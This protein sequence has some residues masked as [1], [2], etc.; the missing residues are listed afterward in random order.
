MTAIARSQVWNEDKT[1]QTS[2]PPPMHALFLKSKQALEEALKFEE[3]YIRAKLETEKLLSKADRD[4]LAKL[5][6]RI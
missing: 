1:L 2:T 5:K 3:Y 4:R 6:L